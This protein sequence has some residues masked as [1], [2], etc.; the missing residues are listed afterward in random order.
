MSIR[1]V[2]TASGVLEGH[3]V[4]QSGAGQGIVLMMTEWA[5]YFAFINKCGT[6]FASDSLLLC[7]AM[8]A[9]FM[10]VSEK[11]KTMMEELIK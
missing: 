7:Q 2:S 11:E 8:K 6:L 9:K 1:R 5:A 3:V 10:S 4:S